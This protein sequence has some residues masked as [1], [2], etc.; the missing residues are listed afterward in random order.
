VLI[1][2]FTQTHTP[3][4]IATL[5][6]LLEDTTG[7]ALDDRRVLNRVG[8]YLT[9]QTQLDWAVALFELNTELFPEDGNLFDS[10]GEAYFLKEDWT[11]AQQAF[12]HALALGEAQDN[13]H[14]CENSRT[15]LSTLDAASR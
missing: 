12:E 2:D 13:C 15:R 11:R 3:D 1:R 7:R 9:D 14:W 6:T 8:L 10:L 5:L 4:Q